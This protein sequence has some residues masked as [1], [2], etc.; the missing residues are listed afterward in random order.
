MFTMSQK[1]EKNIFTS[2]HIRL[3]DV[4][5]SSTHYICYN[6]HYIVVL[7]Q[8]DTRSTYTT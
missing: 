5:Q 2:T 7:T 3:K 1:K 8:R 6:K 4:Q